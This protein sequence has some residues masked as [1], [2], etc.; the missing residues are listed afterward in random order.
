MNSKKRK[1][2]ESES[3]S[4]ED[5]NCIT[6][7]KGEDIKVHVYAFY[8]LHP[9]PTTQEWRKKELW[10]EQ[11]F[12]IH[13]DENGYDEITTAVV[14]GSKLTLDQYKILYALQHEQHFFFWD[15][16]NGGGAGTD[17]PLE[18]QVS[19]W[20]C[21]PKGTTLSYMQK[22]WPQLRNITWRDDDNSFGSL[23]EFKDTK[24]NPMQAVIP[25]YL[26]ISG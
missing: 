21:D 19:M 13:I 14:P 20:F 5:K 23:F 1:L 10:K 12:Y 3:E 6:L 24:L 18:Q 25:V 15:K 16:D 11:T 2:S 7:K 17:D 8:E 9:E 4:S 26:M 22:E